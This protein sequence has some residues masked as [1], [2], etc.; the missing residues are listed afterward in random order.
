MFLPGRYQAD[1]CYLLYFLAWLQPFLCL[2]QLQMVSWPSC[3][4]LSPF[5][6]SFATQPLRKFCSHLT[7]LF[8]CPGSSG[9]PWIPRQVPLRACPRQGSLCLVLLRASLESS[10][11][12]PQ[13]LPPSGLTPVLL[14]ASL[15]SSVGTPQGLP[16]SGLT[17]V[18][19]RASLE[20]S[21]GTPQGLPPSGLS[22]LSPC[23]ALARA[24]DPVSLGVVLWWMKLSTTWPG[25]ASGQMCG[26]DES[27]A[28]LWQWPVDFLCPRPGLSSPVR[29]L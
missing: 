6:V 2:T 20:S 21:A 29:G 3:H 16:P 23:C 17:P 5:K 22:N 26:G 1:L 25:G 24:P 14:R 9:L 4:P 10:A 28:S 7:L 15:E 13:G 19:L 8:S 12:T 27:R 11:G 18:L